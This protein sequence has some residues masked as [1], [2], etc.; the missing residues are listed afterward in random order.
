M[1]FLLFEG[2]MFEKMK[3]IF[4]ILDWDQDGILTGYDLLKTKELVPE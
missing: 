3:F 2:T 4:F 1:S